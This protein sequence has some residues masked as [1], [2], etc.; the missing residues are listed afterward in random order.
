MGGGKSLANFAI[1]VTAFLRQ[2]ALWTPQHYQA[3]PYP[4]HTPPE[5]TCPPPPI[6]TQKSESKAMETL[7]SADTQNDPAFF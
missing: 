2:A 5:L 3:D 7:P 4:A 6:R 1:L